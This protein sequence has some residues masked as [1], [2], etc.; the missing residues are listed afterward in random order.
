MFSSLVISTLIK[1]TFS[2][3]T[4]TLEIQSCPPSFI[5]AHYKSPCIQTFSHDPH[6]DGMFLMARSAQYGSWIEDCDGLEHYSATIMSY[7]CQMLQSC[8]IAAHN[9]ALV[10]WF[11]D[12]IEIEDKWPCNVLLAQMKHACIRCVVLRYHFYISLGLIR[13]LLN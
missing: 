4:F 10:H 13:K 12:R 8:L 7:N 2:H 6:M 5:P 3:N 1:F 11:E 9:E